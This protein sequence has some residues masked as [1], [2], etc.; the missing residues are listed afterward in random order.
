MRHFKSCVFIV[1]FLFV[2]LISQVSA[3]TIT[4]ETFSGEIS[5]ANPVGVFRTYNFGQ[6]YA[7]GTANFTVQIAGGF[8]RYG[9]ITSDGGHF[10]ENPGGGNFDGPVTFGVNAG[11]P[12][13]FFQVSAGGTPA[14]EATITYSFSGSFQSEPPASVTPEIISLAANPQAFEPGKSSVMLSAIAN[15]ACIVDFSIQNSDGNIV[16]QGSVQTTPRSPTQ[17]ADFVWDG[18]INS[19]PAPVGNYIGRASTRGQVAPGREVIF[20]VMPRIDRQLADDGR[21]TG[22]GVAGSANDSPGRDLDPDPKQ[23]PGGGG[24]TPTKNEPPGVGGSGWQAS[25]HERNEAI[26][27]WQVVA[28]FPAPSGICQPGFCDGSFPPQPVQPE[29]PKYVGWTGGTSTRVSVGDPVNIY[30]GNFNW[31]EIDMSFNGRIPMFI[32]RTYNSIDKNIGPFGRGWNSILSS[33][34]EIGATQAVFVNFDGAQYRFTGA[35]GVFVPPQGIELAVASVPGTDFWQITHN[36]A[37]EWTFNGNGKIVRWAKA[38]CGRGLSDGVTFEYDSNSRLVRMQS[39]AGNRFDFSYDSNSRVIA[40]NDSTGRGTGY[41]YDQSG[42]QTA[43]VDVLG[44][45]TEYRYD[46][47]GYLTSV[48][49]SGNRVTTIAYDNGRATLVRS[50]AGEQTSFAWSDNPRQVK[51]TDVGGAEYIYRFDSAGNFIGQTNV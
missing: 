47:E 34:F 2:G 37:D 19:S 3:D 36:K 14:V 28:P 46:S 32:D 22:I 7:T 26:E 17:Q 33:R 10:W 16:A 38:C 1:I 12:V 31:P 23:C 25:G 29:R 35:N 49:Q 39:P 41:E 42:N 50:P 4:F 24:S 21:D 40:V 27:F 6:P 20:T 30:S 51:F 48:T 13:S 44:R 15:I 8:F 5:V 43:F 18:M 9:T 11:Q 45:R